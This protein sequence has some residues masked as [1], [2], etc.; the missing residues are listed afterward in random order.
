MRTECSFNEN[1]NTLTLRKVVSPSSEKESISQTQEE[2]VSDNKFDEL[3][4]ISSNMCPPKDL[5]VPVYIP[6]RPQNSKDDNDNI[7]D[8]GSVSS[9]DS[10]EEEE[11][12]PVP[13]SQLKSKRPIFAQY[14]KITDIDQANI[15]DRREVSTESA[16]ISIVTDCRSSTE[17][18]SR[19]AREATMPFPDEFAYQEFKRDFTRYEKNKASDI[20]EDILKVN[21]LGRTTIPN[22]TSLKE[23]KSETS[24]DTFN[25]NTPNQK[26]ANIRSL[27]TNKYSH[28]SPTLLSYGYREHL[29]NS[30]R[31]TSS[32]SSLRKKQRSCLRRSRSCSVDSTALGSLQSSSSKLSVSFDSRVFVHEYEKPH[33]KYTSNGWSRWFV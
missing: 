23:V 8:D 20:Y 24:T 22:A 31:K 10:F 26:S 9:L 19:C 17:T 18:L 5:P 3:N 13:S 4:S 28:S 21:E 1:E 15:D 6:T 33:D 25:S 16:S 2:T 14:W 32:S 12:F 29:H 30:V 27:F 7:D 11:H